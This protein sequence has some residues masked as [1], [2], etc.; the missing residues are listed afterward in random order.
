MD[1]SGYVSDSFYEQNHNLPN[2]GE[3]STAFWDFSIFGEFKR[4]S[5]GRKIKFE[6]KHVSFILY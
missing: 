4:V 2:K 5:H 1:Y 6:K 3:N